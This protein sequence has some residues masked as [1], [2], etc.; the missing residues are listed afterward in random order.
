MKRLTL[1][2]VLSIMMFIGFSFGNAILNKRT[3]SNPSNYVNG[4]IVQTTQTMC[5]GPVPA[6]WLIKD[7]MW[8]PTSCGNPTNIVNN[9]YVIVRYDNLP[10]GSVL[11]VC[12]QPVP[13]EWIQVSTTWCPTCCGK[14]TQITNNVMSIKKL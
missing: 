11:S 4:N 13:N 3:N 8:S 14:P 12:T 7:E 6:G 1:I 9:V 2:S 10:S 5:A